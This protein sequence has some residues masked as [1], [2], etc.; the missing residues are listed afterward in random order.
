MVTSSVLS[1]ISVPLESEPELEDVVAELAPEA[2][3]PGALPLTVDN[4]EGNVLHTK[5]HTHTHA[6]THTHT[7]THRKHTERVQREGSKTADIDICILY[8]CLL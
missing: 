3:L 7:H 2:S 5:H 6:R 1:A 4:L 8:V